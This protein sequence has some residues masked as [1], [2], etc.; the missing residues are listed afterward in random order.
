MR[1]IINGYFLAK[2]KTGMGQYL[3]NILLNQKWSLDIAILIPEYLKDKTQNLPSNILKYIQYIPIWYSRNDLLAQ[4]IWEKY[5][6]PREANSHKADLLW[7]PHPTISYTPNIRHIMTV[8]DVI[9][10]RLP[11]YIPNWKV[12]LYVKLLEKSILRADKIITISNFSA[13]EIE[14]IFR[15]KSKKIPI[16]SPSSPKLREQ[17]TDPISQ[18]KYLFYEGGLDI[19]KNVPRLI[20]AFSL[21]N[22]KYPSLNL[23][24]AGNYFNSPIIPNIPNIISK[25]NLH[26][27][28]KLL[29][30][31]SDEDMINYI[32]HAEAL[33]Y[34]SLYEGFGIPILEGFGLGTPVITSNLGA[35]SE[36]GAEAVI[37]VNPESSKSIAKG[38]DNLLTDD[39]LRQSLIHKGKERVKKFN[40]AKSA[41]ELEMV[42]NTN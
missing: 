40:W 42:F 36:I 11:E 17:T 27:K 20:E 26:D 41:L 37:Q 38:I 39:L 14:S 32:K 18:D 34:P 6:I 23:Y 8:H 35:M 9:Y 31:I 16:I 15:I 29:G 3:L 2:P 21:I 24:I 33:V 10:W 1:L 19:R 12:R 7:S 5:I 28:V 13:K 4:I 22:N 25:H 30:Y